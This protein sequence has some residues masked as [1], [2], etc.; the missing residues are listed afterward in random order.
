MLDKISPSI[1][2][3]KDVRHLL[4]KLDKLKTKRL[5]I[6]EMHVDIMDGKF[7]KNK[8][9]P[10]ITLMLELGSR[11]YIPEVHL[12]VEEETLET[13]IIKAIRLGSK[14]IWIHVELENAERYLNIV[15]NLN[16][17]EQNKSVAIGLAIN[18]DTDIE[19]IEYFKDKI[20]SVLLMSVFPGRSGQKFLNRSY[21]RIKEL[22]KI[23]GE[24]IE[25]V[26]DGGINRW[27]IKKVLKVGANKV[28]LGHYLTGNMF[29]LKGKLKWIKRSV[30]KMKNKEQ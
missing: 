25:I 14:K 8:F 20:D 11:G 17:Q 18:P 29:T 15:N 19:E 24:N 7:V 26:V 3:V 21:K 6:G 9:E 22:R 30:M 5:V 28:V 1:L 4:D 2:G 27:N 23:I 12:M 13:E 16:N 10:S